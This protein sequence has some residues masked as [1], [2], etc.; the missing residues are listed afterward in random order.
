MNI[1]NMGMVYEDASYGYGECTWLVPQNI[2]VFQSSSG[3]TGALRLYAALEFVGRWLLVCCGHLPCILS[4]AHDVQTHC[5]Y[6]HVAK[7]DHAQNMGSNVN[8]AYVFVGAPAGLAFNFIASF[9]GEGGSVPVVF[10]F[11]KGAAY[12]GTEAKDAVAKMVAGKADKTTPL[13][14]VYVSTNNLTFF[15]GGCIGDLGFNEMPDETPVK[16]I[17]MYLD[18]SCRSLGDDSLLGVTARESKISQA[19]HLW[20]TCGPHARLGQLQCC[21]IRLLGSGPR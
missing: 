15:S 6:L 9:T 16:G 21:A 10:V 18:T 14:G 7:V 17:R 3:G 13:Q 8:M 19:W 1:K 4:Q 20:T 5:M 12:Q 2:Y 11:K